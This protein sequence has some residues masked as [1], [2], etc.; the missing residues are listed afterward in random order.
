M[1]NTNIPV[2]TMS[3]LGEKGRFGNQIFQ[4]AFLKI[5]ARV[6]NMRVETPRWV[7]QYL[8]GHNDPPISKNL[9]VISELRQKNLQRIFAEPVPRYKNVDFAGNFQFHTSS[10]APYKDYFQ[11]LFIP[12]PEIKAE[13]DKGLAKLISR[14]KTIIGLHIRRGDYKDYRGTNKQVYFY[15]APTAWYKNWLRTIW[16]K[17]PDPVLFIAS[18]E[19]EA[20]T[21][22][23]SE[24]HPVTMQDLFSSLPKNYFYPDFY[25]LTQCHILAIS[26]S[27]FSFTA[28]ML[29]NKAKSFLRPVL[30]LKRL[31][32]YNPWASDPLL[33]IVRRFY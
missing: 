7:G 8:F 18:D 17:V 30:H 27:S 3:T 25:L 16:S 32:P 15:I 20:V 10:F 31:H 28:S 29:N 12:V 21:P 1:V 14:G 26:N 33:N 2:V 24:Y 4:Y 22:D 5:Y 13:M 9:P 6:F 23:F 11:S 19:I